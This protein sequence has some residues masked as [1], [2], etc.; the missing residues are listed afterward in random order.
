MVD[1]YRLGTWAAALA[2]GV[3]FGPSAL[4]QPRDVVEGHV[5]ELSEGDIV[6]D[7][8]RARGASD[9]AIV[10]LWRPLA[11]KHPLTGQVIAER[12]LIGRLRLVQVR[13]ALSL[14]R[15]EGKLARAAQAGDVVILRAPKSR[16]VGDGAA[17]AVP[18][19]PAE[20]SPAPPPAAATASKP[21]G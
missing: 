13:E 20:A 9:G 19:A 14:A 12:F 21:L 17:P 10:E 15:A 3:L 4:A 11:V 6:V 7:L 5:I 16:V 18:V 1:G 2:M 8:A